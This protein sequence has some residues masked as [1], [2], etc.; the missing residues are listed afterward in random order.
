MAAHSFDSVYAATRSRVW[1]LCSRLLP[2]QDAED[3][4]Q[5]VFTLVYRYLPGFAGRSTVDTWV[6]RI[7]VNYLWRARKRLQRERT[8]PLDATPEPRAR[9]STPSELLAVLRQI[10]DT[11]D[12]L[13]A[14]IVTLALF[15]DCRQTEIAEI[16][17]IPVGTVYSRLSR[18]K[19]LIRLE[20][21]RHGYEHGKA[22]E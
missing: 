20:L 18:A 13:S 10:I 19:D 11:M 14:R 2:G 17:Q 1:A 8:V 9:E 5:E 7:A 16:L 4:L 6:Y 12:D 21:R 3:A 15:Q 22:T